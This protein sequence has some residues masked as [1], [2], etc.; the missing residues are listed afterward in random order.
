MQRTGDSPDHYINNK[1]DSWL[2]KN[3]H[4]KFT[5]CI[6]LFKNALK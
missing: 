1:T 5:K 4:I 3:K 6:P 2:V